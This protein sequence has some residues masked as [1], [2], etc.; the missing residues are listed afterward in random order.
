ME[1]QTEHSNETTKQSPPT[2]DIYGRHD[3][4]RDLRRPANR[5]ST[6]GASKLTTPTTQSKFP[7]VMEIEEQNDANPVW[8]SSLD[9]ILKA[10][11]LYRLDDHSWVGV[12]VCSAMPDTLHD[13]FW[14][15]WIILTFGAILK[16]FGSTCETHWTERRTPNTREVQREVE[17]VDYRKLLSEVKSE[18]LAIV[19]VS[20]SKQDSCSHPMSQECRTAEEEMINCLGLF[21]TRQTLA[22]MNEAYEDEKLSR[23]QVYFWYN[24]SRSGRPLTSTTDR[25]IGQVRDLIVADRKITIDNLSEILVISYGSCQKIHW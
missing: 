8:T 12:D 3:A 6:P 15:R 10:M 13:V 21:L 22:L 1:E 24:D 5:A 20:Q 17:S 23:T 7:Q 18:R 11:P 16:G 4:P 19:E 14:A 25:N 2:R 9:Q